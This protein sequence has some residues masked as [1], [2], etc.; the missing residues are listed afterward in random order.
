MTALPQG[1][2]TLLFTDIEGSTRLSATLGEEYADLLEEHRRLLRAAAADCGGL[3]VDTQGDAFFFVFNG[4]REAVRAAVEAQRLLAPLGDR[5]RVRMGVHT[6][7]P[8]LTA[9]GY[10]V[11]VDLSFTARICAAA[12]GGQIIVSP[13]TRELVGAETALVD[14]GEHV[15]KDIAAPVRLFQVL[16]QGLADQFPPPRARPPGHLAQA[17]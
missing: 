13:T 8:Q 14:L 15:L 3:E 2:L 5:L 9:A 11:G 16:E 7:E 17:K 4:A 12:H 6:G 1:T 10:Y